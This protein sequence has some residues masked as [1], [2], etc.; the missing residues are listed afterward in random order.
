[1]ASE[2]DKDTFIRASPDAARIVILLLLLL[3]SR[4]LPLAFVIINKLAFYTAL[5]TD[6]YDGTQR[7]HKLFQLQMTLC[8]ELMLAHGAGPV[9]QA[10]LDQ[11][12][13]ECVALYFTSLRN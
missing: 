2:Y 1:M 11:L 13:A 3:F 5:Q 9:D 7:V 12:R 6:H 10:D 4:R 8:H